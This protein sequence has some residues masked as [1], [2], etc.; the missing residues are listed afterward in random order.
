MLK[1]L[2]IKG[3]GCDF[4]GVGFISCFKS[5]SIVN[6]VH[7]GKDYYFATEGGLVIG[8]NTHISRRVT[9]YTHNHDYDGDALPYDEKKVFKPVIISKNV[10]IG[11]NVSICPGVSIGEGS[12][13]GMGSVV[14]KDVP[15]FTICGGNPALP[16]GNR[17]IEKYKYLELNSFYGG[18]NG[19]HINADKVCHCSLHEL[20]SNLCFVLSTGRSGSKAIIDTFSRHNDI[21]GYH[22]PFRHLIKLS[23]DYAHK[24]KSEDQVKR[25]LSVF[26]NQIHAFPI[27]KKI[28]ISDQKFSNLANFIIEMLPQAKFIHLKRNPAKC[29]NSIYAREWYASK[30]SILKKS[31]A[32]WH[33]FRINGSQVG[34]FREDEWNDLTRWEKCCWYYKYWNKLIEELISPVDED[35]KISISIDSMESVISKIN[36]FLGV[37]E[38]NLKIK[39]QQSTATA[40]QPL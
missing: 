10:W 40:C 29:I 38:C 28:L 9:I 24:E 6:N 39:N 25:E 23:T 3:C 7:I 26:F 32:Y 13:I 12:I 34:A 4:K 17:N 35:Q 37:S 8:D 21:I 11:M 16:I 5:F 31:T 36:T 19:S 30:F 2:V 15:P 14:T 33:A 20:G 22:E 18:R 1:K 27:G